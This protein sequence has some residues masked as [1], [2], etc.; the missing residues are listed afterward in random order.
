MA[1][2]G[3]ATLL[4][5]IKQAGS[6]ILDHF[7]V[8]LGD[9][10]DGVKKAAEFL[11]SFIEAYEAQEK[12]VNALTQTMVKNGI[13]TTEL[14]KV[15][16]DY[17]AAIQKTTQ[18]GD[19]EVIAAENILQARLG[20]KKV[21]M[22]LLQATTDLATGQKIDLASAA[23]MVS[24]AMGT[25]NNTLKRMGI[26]YNET[27]DSGE[28]MG[29][30]IEAINQKFG[31]QAVAATQGLGSVKQMQ[32][33]WS[34]FQEVVGQRLSPLFT[35]AVKALTNF[36]NTISKGGGILDDIVRGIYQVSA[37]AVLFARDFEVVGKVIGTVL[38]GMA[39]TQQN[40]IQGK[41]KDAWQ[42]AKNIVNFS[43]ED[44]KKANEDAYAKIAEMDKAYMEGKQGDLEREAALEKQALEN[45]KTYRQA[46]DEDAAKN[47]I[48]KMTLAQN[49]RIQEQ[50][51]EGQN[52]VQR[53][54]MQVKMLDEK[55]AKEENFQT[56]LGMVRQRADL[57]EIQRQKIANQQQLQMTSSMQTSRADIIGAS[58]DLIA[59][60]G[61]KESKAVF[62][63]QKA[64][65]LA[66]VYIATQV[67]SAMALAA[68]PG[69][70]ATI[71]LAANVETLGYIKMAAIG[72]TAIKGL[73]TGGIVPATSGGQLY[74][75]GEGGKD[76]AVIPL[77]DPS[78][79][80]RLGMG[81]GVSV[82]F[83]GPVLG[84][85]SQ[86]RQ[87]AEVIDVQLMKLRQSGASVSMEST[88]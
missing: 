2:N 78:T 13:Y 74:Q 69:P 87:F 64:A 5:R 36:F 54:A 49:L 81:G 77:D 45:K 79:K 60:L 67:A 59:A 43:M 16:E 62:L 27:S 9:I 88:F 66:Q 14:R 10:V 23:E 7:V 75:L 32:N 31:G 1:S 53:A 85:E 51:M 33:A 58:G 73:A 37:Q 80:D 35:I 83:H 12:A 40:L 65:G 86:A 41:F 11:Y 19:E 28:R 47:Q 57:I 17:A 18:Y 8:T 68:P 55:I 84:D 42:S 4:I 25:Q 3:E 50:E 21:T 61:D 26:Q 52:E 71:P 6:E 76:E 24:K 20:Q 72:A 38:G 22:E 48:E 56:K 44:I 30:I 63:L 34:D 46:F 70:P 39:E 82:H 29:R 15:Y